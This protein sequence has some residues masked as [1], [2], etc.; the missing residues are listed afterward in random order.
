MIIV[1]ALYCMLYLLYELYIYLDLVTPLTF[2][3]LFAKIIAHLS[4]I[5]LKNTN[6][7]IIF[8]GRGGLVYRSHQW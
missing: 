3:R 8:S 7:D 4:S 1:Y 2:V 5:E 6:N